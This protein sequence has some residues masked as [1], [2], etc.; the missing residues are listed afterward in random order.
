MSNP[1][2]LRAELVPGEWIEALAQVMHEGVK[3][4]RKSGDW[5]ENA[6][7]NPDLFIGALVRHYIAYRKGEVKEDHLAA[8]AVNALILRSAGYKNV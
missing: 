1:N 6:Q 8:I 7:E 4:G 5:L 2:K 3:N